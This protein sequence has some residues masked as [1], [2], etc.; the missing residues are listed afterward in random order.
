MK[1]LGENFTRFFFC[2]FCFL[3]LIHWFCEGIQKPFTIMGIM[4][5]NAELILM[6]LL[7]LPIKLY[8]KFFPRYLR[9]NK[10]IKYE[11]VLF[12]TLNVN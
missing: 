12:S 1:V 11:C 2:L 7:V 4:S 8:L 10:L 3:N 5:T 9:K 6:I